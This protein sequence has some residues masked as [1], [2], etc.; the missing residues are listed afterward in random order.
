MPVTAATLLV[1]LALIFAVASLVPP[2]PGHHLL[3]VA[4]ILVSVAMLAGVAVHP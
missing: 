3:A 2:W 4:V 1:I